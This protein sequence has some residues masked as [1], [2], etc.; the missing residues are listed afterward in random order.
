MKPKIK[1]KNFNKDE[2]KNKIIKYTNDIWTPNEKKLVKNSIIKNSWFCIDEFYSGEQNFINHDIELDTLNDVNYKMKKIILIL[3]YKQKLIINNWLKIC[4]EMYNSSL[5]YIKENI[6]KDKKVLNFIY[7]RSKLKNTKENLINKSSVRVHDVDYSIKLAC[8]NY[9]T[10][11]TNYKNG[12]IKKFRIRYWNKKQKI[13]IMNLEKSN[14]NE[15]GFRYK[16]LG[17]V[18]GFYNNKE[19]DFNKIK[20]DCKLQKKEN[21]YYLFVPEK[22]EKKENENKNKII[23]ID[24]GIRTFG[25]GISEKKVIKIGDKFSEKIKKYFKR[26]DKILEN[27]KIDIKIKIKNEKKINKKVEN[28]INELHWKTINYLVKN[29]KT[30]LIGNMSTKSIVSKYNKLNKMTKRVAMSMNLYKFKER[31]KYKSNIEK[32][33]Y[34]EINESYTSKSCSKCGNIKEDLGSK[35]VY[36]CEKCKL[37]LDRDI[38]GAKNIYI[39]ALK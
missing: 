31:L 11:L 20:Y 7:L 38:N 13:K 2:L 28:L 17:K 6:K 26:K 14:F 34:K 8:Q 25:M 12:Y 36:N 5:K 4:S 24:P 32:V 18:K 37:K 1:I 30:I 39:K 27:K 29:Y 3:T 35:K 19:Y 15:K 21:K 22:I 10:S 9:K 16:I 23:S 33:N